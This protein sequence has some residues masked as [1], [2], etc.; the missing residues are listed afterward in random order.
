MYAK[1]TGEK[2]DQKMMDFI[3]SNSRQGRPVFVDGFGPDK[4]DGFLKQVEGYPVKIGLAYLPLHHLTDRVAKRNA[5]AKA[6]G[7]E[8][9]V[10]SYEQITRQFL[11]HF[12][13][14]E[15]G[16]PVIG[17]IS[18]Q[19]VELAFSKMQPKDSNEE[20]ALKQL[21]GKIVEEYGLRS[22][23]KIPLTGRFSY[24]VLVKTKYSPKESVGQIMKSYE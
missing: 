3:C 4:I 20:E 19:K 21:K 14:A 11:E 6:T 13:R 7:D 17:Y 5:T 18:L 8:A 15:E 2:V 16:D 12:K 1:E 22:S 9:E 10:R 24:H 23:D